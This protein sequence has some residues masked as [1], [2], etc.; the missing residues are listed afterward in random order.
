MKVRDDLAEA[1]RLAW[2]HLARPGSWWTGPQRVELAT[3]V[4]LSIDDADPLPPWVAVTSSDRLPD[5]RVAPDLAHDAAYRIGR[6]AGTI[7]PEVYRRFADGI[8]ELAYVELCAI[9]S[10]TA[11]VVHFCRNIGVDVPPFPA[12]VAGD[13]TGDRPD[14]LAEAELNWVPVAAPADQTAA[15]IQAYSAVPAEWENTWRLGAAQYIPHEEMIDPAWQ[16]SADSLS[17]PQIELVA[18]RIAQIRE[19]FY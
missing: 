18:S 16:R 14:V 9:A 12:P 5:E 19:C 3:T 1:H 10:S 13:P 7:T 4:K 11:A 8:G 15:V 17:R 2:E 6:H